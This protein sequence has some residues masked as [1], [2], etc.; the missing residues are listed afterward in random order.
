VIRCANATE[1]YD[2]MFMQIASNGYERQSVDAHSPETNSVHEAQL[3]TSY[4]LRNH[5][6]NV[7]GSR[8]IDLRWA[9]ASVLHF[10]SA[11]E[12]AGVL[13]RYNKHASRF[14][15]DDQ[16]IGAYGVETV[17]SINACIERLKQFPSSRRA[18]A[19]LGGLNSLEENCNLPRCISSL[20][21]IIGRSGL[22]LLV[23]QRSL[24]LGVMPYDC[25]LL[26][27]VLEYA[28]AALCV[29]PFALKWFV[30]SLHA[31]ATL[32][33]HASNPRNQGMLLPACIL[34]DRCAC[35]ECLHHPNRLPEPFKSWLLNESEVRT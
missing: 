24:S 31:K 27:N 22:E 7:V 10:F 5:A 20:H 12:R 34:A 21:F 19:S 23:Y 32:F 16:L 25:V 9:A 17:P 4:E 3:G 8:S 18:V 6:H 33:E 26:C 13:R 35:E 2:A 30:G 1:L 29:L 14:L 11:T 28:S 15:C